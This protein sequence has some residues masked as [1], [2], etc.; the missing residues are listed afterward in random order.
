[1]GV[2][3]VVIAVV[4]AVVGCG[5]LVG[6]DPAET[7]PLPGR[8]AYLG[9]PEP[10]VVEAFSDWAGPPAT[11]HISS[12]I[13]QGRP[14]TRGF[15]E[16][17]GWV[18]H[19]LPD[20][21]RSTRRLVLSVPLVP[22]GSTLASVLEGDGHRRLTKL[23]AALR[24]SGHGRS[25][26]RLGWESNGPW[27]PRWFADDDPVGYRRAFRKVVRT[28]RAAAP[29]L[30]FE[31]NVICEPLPRS[32]MWY[33]GHH[34]VDIVG[35]DCYARS[36]SER[37]PWGRWREALDSVAA[38]ARDRGK[39]IAIS[40]WGTS[41]DDPDLV[42]NFLHWVQDNSVAYHIYWN[43]P[44]NPGEADTRLAGQPQAAAAYRQ[45]GA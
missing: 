42:R 39:R 14:G 24:S 8:G 7:V 22:A 38:F 41:L 32:P 4:A 43:V 44:P 10:A 17:D 25:V 30:Q 5:A 34:Y 6:C 3:S 16:I 31:W 29:R 27:F 23:A 11:T 37:D 36:E 33:P 21:Q 9:R 20:V 15:L 12:F 26:I 19:V 1:M 40:E 2:R 18:T 35:Q 28:L 13:P 45:N